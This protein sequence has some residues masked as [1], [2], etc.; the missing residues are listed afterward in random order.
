VTVRGSRIKV[1]L[2]GWVIL[3]ADILKD[4]DYMYPANRFRGKKLRKGH[5][6]FAGHSDPVQF[7]N[8]R[9]KPVKKP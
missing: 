9:I 4:A 6:G 5:F 2:N 3:D 7:R 8:V 1:E